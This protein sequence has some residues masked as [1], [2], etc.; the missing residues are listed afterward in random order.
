MTNNIGKAGFFGCSSVIRTKV[1]NK[2]IVKVSAG[3]PV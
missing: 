1:S 2:F 3:R